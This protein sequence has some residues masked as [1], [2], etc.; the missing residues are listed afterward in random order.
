MQP[1]SA[2]LFQLFVL[3]LALQVF[4]GVA[5]YE[6]MRIGWSEANPILVSAFSY[7]G[8]GPALLLFKAKACLLLVLLHRN[9]SHRSVPPVLVFLAAVYT[10][11]SLVP[12][13][14]KFLS[15]LI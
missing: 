5:T 7:L 3:N 2:R 14:A 11:F 8:V 15:L 4:D 9:G 12:W 13:L 10:I 6:G 1:D